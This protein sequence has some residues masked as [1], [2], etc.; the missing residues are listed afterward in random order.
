M[1]VQSDYETEATVG[2]L[3]SSET[4]DAAIVQL[5]GLGIPSEEIQ[6]AHAPPGTYSCLDTSGGDE[7]NAILSGLVLGAPIGAIAGIGLGALTGIAGQTGFGLLAIIAAVMGSV[8]GS[9]VGAEAGAHYDDDT[10]TSVDLRAVTTAEVLSVRT[11][12]HRLTLRVRGA[13][14]RAGALALLDPSLIL[15]SWAAAAEHGEAPQHERRDATR[16]TPR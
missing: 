15:I 13:L 7:V 4:T 6:R 3:A 10:I 16:F 14:K 5:R 2:L 12:S 8:I 11:H 9:V 1:E